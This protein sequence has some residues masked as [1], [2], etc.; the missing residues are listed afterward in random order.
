MQTDLAAAIE[1]YYQDKLNL[2]AKPG[3]CIAVINCQDPIIQQNTDR[4]S[5]IIYFNAPQ[6]IHVVDHNIMDGTTLVLSGNALKL[7]GR[8]NLLNLCAALTVAK[9][10]GVDIYSIAGALSEFTGLP[11]RLEVLGQH[12]GLTFVDDSISTTPESTMAALEAFS[13]NT[14]TLLLGGKD[15]R[16]DF[17]QL[18]KQLARQQIHAV[19]TMHENG[20]RIAEDIKNEL[21]KLDYALVIFQEKDLHAA[22]EKA[23][24]ITPQGGVVLLSPASPSYDAYKNF[25]ER[26]MLFR[27]L[28]CHSSM[29]CCK[30]SKD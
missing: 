4:F 1:Q 29:P 13:G 16:Q 25:Q 17:T 22:L 30:T 28:C 2:F 5:N 20:D 18:A 10:L 6:A 12:R 11:H 7:R 21:K 9:Y 23:K 14:I 27:Q 3:N 8:H 24:T 15:R 26:G 19:I